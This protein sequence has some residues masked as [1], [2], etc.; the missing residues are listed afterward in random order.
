MKG[1]TA[2][3]GCENYGQEGGGLC[4]LFSE[5]FVK[6][7][8]GE[9]LEQQAKVIAHEKARVEIFANGQAT[10]KANAELEDGSLESVAHF[11]TRRSQKATNTA[12]LHATFVAVSTT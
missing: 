4:K 1:G 8:P 7:H 9:T 3:P 11:W 2:Y 10:R 12:P 6:S 5:E